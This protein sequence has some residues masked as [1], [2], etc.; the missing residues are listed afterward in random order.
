M[1]AVYVSGHGW[2]HATRTAEVLRVVRQRAPKLP[3]VV[4]TDAPAFLFEE[5][6]DPPLAI[7]ALR[8]DVGPVSYTHLTLPTKRIV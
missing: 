1:L 3:I 4:S 2:G 8:V 5:V 7:R 6:I